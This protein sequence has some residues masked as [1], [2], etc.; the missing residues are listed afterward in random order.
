MSTFSWFILSL[1]CIYV[2]DVPAVMVACNYVI[3]A[4]RLVEYISY[5]K[6][7]YA[8]FFS[9]IRQEPNGHKKMF[10]LRLVIVSL[11]MAITIQA[12]LIAKMRPIATRPISTEQPSP[13]DGGGGGPVRTPRRRNNP[14]RRDVYR[15]STI[16]E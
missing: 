15:R 9:P 10:Y 3:S 6:L 13:P 5:L 4:Y 8:C 2:G 1:I 11:L 16:T 12:F 7:Q 14:S